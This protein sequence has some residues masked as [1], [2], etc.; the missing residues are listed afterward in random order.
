MLDPLGEFFD[1][2]CLIVEVNE[3]LLSLSLSF[4]L[5]LFILFMTKLHVV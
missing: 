3:M 4:Y 5:F 2:I 1:N